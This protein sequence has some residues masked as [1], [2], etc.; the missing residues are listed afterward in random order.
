MKNAGEGPSVLP[1][2][3][4]TLKAMTILIIS[5]VAI[6]GILITAFFHI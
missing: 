3:L 2:Q 5:I 4:K 1:H 6:I